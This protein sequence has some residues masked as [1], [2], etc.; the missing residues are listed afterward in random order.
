MKNLIIVLLLIAIPASYSSQTFTNS[1]G[2]TQMKSSSYDAD[3][4]KKNE[5][6]YANSTELFIEV[7]IEEY[8][9][10]K[11]LRINLNIGDNY[12]SLLSKKEDIKLFDSLVN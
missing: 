8:Y 2:K 7:V 4:A 11:G 3:K 5:Y 12:N 9:N 10:G 6:W 1:E